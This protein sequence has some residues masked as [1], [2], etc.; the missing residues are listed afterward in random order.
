MQNTQNSDLEKGIVALAGIITF[1]LF[2][3]GVNYYGGINNFLLVLGNFLSFNFNLTPFLLMLLKIGGVLIVLFIVY[4]ILKWLFGRIAYAKDEIRRIKNE[5][6]EIENLLLKTLSFDSKLLTID[7]ERFKEKIKVCVASK[8]LKHFLPELKKRLAKANELLEDA[9]KERRKE[10]RKMELS[11]IERDIE[12][13]DKERRIKSTYEESNAGMI[14]SQLETWRNNVFIKAKLSKIQ[15]KALEKK[16]FKQVNEYSVKEN[17]FIRVLVKPESNHKATHVFLVWDT[18]RLLKT[19]KGV[20]N[21]Q[22]HLSIDA[23]ITFKFNNKKYALE[24]ERGD[25]LRKDKQAQEKVAELT[26]KYRKRWMFIVSNKNFLSGYQ[27]L[28]FSTQRR[29]VSENLK[30]LLKI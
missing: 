3:L 11:Q 20:S 13:K 7:I 19:I 16:G 1:I 14:C 26:R 10:A 23:D 15:I 24:I 27:K 12:E 28:G 22:E 30:K 17:R 29:W 5:T 2:F 6:I 21:I 18:I 4:K 8:E 9:E 25:L